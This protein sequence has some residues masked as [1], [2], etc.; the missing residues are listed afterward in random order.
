MLPWRRQIGDARTHARTNEGCLSAQSVH[1]NANAN[2]SASGSRAACRVARFVDS[3]AAFGSAWTALSC[4]ARARTTLGWA[5]PGLGCHCIAI[6]FRPRGGAWG[7][8]GPRLHAPA[9]TDRIMPFPAGQTGCHF[10]SLPGWLWARQRGSV[11][12]HAVACRV[13]IGPCLLSTV[14]HASDPS[15][16]LGGL[17]R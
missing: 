6:H 17:G 5:G 4:P 15:R 10:P 1:T 7:L 13:R 3:A 9:I 11:C 8:V 14:A 16:D 2:A 12:R